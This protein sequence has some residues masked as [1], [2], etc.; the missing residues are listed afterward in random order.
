MT[1]SNPGLEPSP[2]PIG[3]S[4]IGTLDLTQCDREPVQFPGAIMPHGYLLLLSG[5]DHQLIGAST[6]IRALFGGPA[7]D[8]LGQ[9][10]EDLFHSSAHQTLAR[11]LARITSSRPPRY[12][13]CVSAP[14][15]WDPLDAF[16]HRMGDYLILELEALD[17]E[18]VGALLTE[19]SAEV[20][21]CA[22]ALQ[23]AAT[24][25]E[26]LESVVRDIK[27]LSGFDSVKGVRFV[28]DGSFQVIAEARG[29][30]F[31]AF[32]DKR[33][34]RSDIPDPGRRQML[35]MPTQYAPDLDYAPVPL[36]MAPGRNGPG[37]IDLGF[38]LLRSISPMCNRFYL[39]VGVRSR[40][41]LTLIDQGELWGFI[42]CWHGSPRR[43]SYADRLAYQN[44]A[45]V[46]S[47]SLVEKEKAGR[48]R[49][50]LD[51]KRRM[52][53]IV[54]GLSPEQPVNGQL[55][56]IPAA[57]MASLDIDGAAL[58]LGPSIVRAGNTPD[59]EAIEA[60]LPW[61]DEQPAF[62][63]T[64]RWP[65]E[66]CAAPG[67]GVTGLL[68]ARL[69]EPG[70][71]LLAFRPEWVHEVKWAGD[72][73]KP[74]EQIPGAAPGE[75]RLTAR[76]SFEEWKQVV[77]GQS[78]PWEDTE[79]EALKDLQTAIK[80]WQQAQKLRVLM[81]RLEA[82]N[83]ELKNFA[84]TV[85]HDLQEPLRG[86]SNFGQFLD[87]SIG[88]TLA[89]QERNWLTG[90]RKLSLR[91]SQ[92]IEA[93]LHFSRA[94]QQL[95]DMRPIDL[96]QLLTQVQESLAGRISETG[97]EIILPPSWPAFRGDP[98]R[99]RVVLENLIAN[100]MKYNDQ[101]RPRIE[102]GLMDSPVP[103]IF[104]QDNG[105]GIAE[106]HREAIFDVFRRLHGRDE[107]GGGTGAGLAIARKHVERHGGRLWVESAPGGGSRFL[108]TLE[109]DPA[110]ETNRPARP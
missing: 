103:T 41:V 25:E 72:P 86:I 71:Y 6:N 33:F 24:W 59:S 85:S 93:L 60:M 74:V 45:Q 63:Q 87:D 32:L 9:P 78:R 101:A 55:E 80:L 64:D 70:Q 48:Y 53:A 77:K 11:G 92:Q 18:P 35:L 38:S 89:T 82:S 110:L 23:S 40:L 62:Y 47:L 108:F 106:N 8:L 14:K 28:P 7:E 73:R 16:A 94:S 90:I 96:G 13:G 83:E 17:S 31:P 5:E 34:P 44:L 54:Q 4:A 66:G 39:N 95:L 37:E 49:R 61:L 50:T 102:I 76:G 105:I 52:N 84:Y 36:I 22:E 100:A 15:S 29:E 88:G 12:L 3:Q 75:F 98:E 42:S 46:A 67:S 104:V 1:S 43:V 97:A 57:L 68:A 58:C 27:R 99:I 69:M 10:L 30:V 65:T 51:A 56:S 91:M 2:S 81:L 26:G 107:Y 20:M 109:A 19:R 21:H 79:C